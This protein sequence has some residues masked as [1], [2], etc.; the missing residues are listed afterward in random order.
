MTDGSRLGRREFIRLGAAMPFGAAGTVLAA[1]PA[2]SVRF[3]ADVPVYGDYDVAVFGAGPAGIGAAVSA[4]RAGRKT[5]LVERY[6]FAGGVGTWG[7]MGIFFLF[8]D[9][10]AHPTRQIIRGLS[11]EVVRT[12]DRRGAASV[13]RDNKCAEPVGKPIGD[14]PLLGKVGFEPE[15]LRLVYHDLLSS[16]GVVKLFMS[17]LAG[18]IRDG[19]RVTAAVVSC[20]EGP[21]AIRAKTFV[22]ATG[23]AQ[24]VHL[25][26]GATRQVPPDET[27]HKSLFAEL[28]GVAPHDIAANKRRYAE[29]LKAGKLPEGVWARMGFMQF[30]E[31]EHV[32]LPV[33]YAVGDCCSSADMTRM[34]AELRR[35]NDELLRVYRREMPGY[36][37]AY[38]VNSSVQVGS[39]DG[40]HA[41]GRAT[42]SRAYLQGDVDAAD[43]MLPIHRTWGLA[44]ATKQKEGFSTRDSGYAKGLRLLPFGTLVPQDFD[45][46]LVAGRCLSAEPDVMASCRMM[47]TCM[48]MGQVVGTAAALAQDRRIADVGTVPHGELV[49]RL[50]AA[51]CVCR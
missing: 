40:R 3:S 45:N 38:F 42:L 18:V 28:C 46:V 37:N 49:D 22:D 16:A 20:L 11:D 50:E 35:T 19:R 10:S 27:M 1:E 48:A 17:N 23:D 43:G 44:H 41:V 29:L 36:A 39:R 26:G 33:A 9:D 21:R 14:A 34:D 4:A 51:Q 7:S 2:D 47:T 25:A 30:R 12:L 5:I 31:K 8:E 6:N 24:L 13:M 32:Q 15:D